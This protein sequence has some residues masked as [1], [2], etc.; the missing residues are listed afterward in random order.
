MECW[1]LA[2]RY[3][4]DTLIRVDDGSKEFE[5][6]SDGWVTRSAATGAEGTRVGAADVIAAAGEQYSEFVK[7]ASLRRLRAAAERVNRATV[8]AIEAPLEP[9]RGRLAGATA[10]MLAA[11]RDIETLYAGER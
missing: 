4:G 7:R 6:A 8:Q 11:I 9:Q 2:D 10:A 5:L 3:P 1:E